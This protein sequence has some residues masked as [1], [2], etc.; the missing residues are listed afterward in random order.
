MKLEN[1]VCEIIYFTPSYGE[2]VLPIH[3]QVE[4]PFS[5]KEIKVKPFTVGISEDFP[6]HLPVVNELQ[7]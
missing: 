4:L 7:R 1:R 3:I 5:T 2:Y 6:V